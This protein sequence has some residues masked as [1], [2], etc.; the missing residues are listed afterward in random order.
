MRLRDKVVVITGS[1]RGIG[2]AVAEACAR[3]GAK[4]VIC[5]RRKFEVD[6]TCETLRRQGSQVTGLQVDVSRE[7]DLKKLMQHA[8]ETWKRID[9]WIN[10]AGVSGGYRFLYDLS[11]DEI[12]DI[13]DINIKGTLLACKLIIP[14]FIKNKGGILINMSG[15]GGRCETA[16]FLT[17][18]AATKAAVTSFTKSL[19]SEN[20]NYPI[21]IHAVIPG[22]VATDFYKDLKTSPDLTQEIRNLPHILKA[23]GVPADAVGKAIAQIACQVPGKATGRQYSLLSGGRL[24]RAIGLVIWYRIT[25]RMK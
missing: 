8:I 11:S 23:F 20:K 17:T 18:Y 24:L 4:I 7:D 1:T 25:G 3:E 9:V 21:S 6:K 22:M 14:Y 15:K 12:A 13:I 5:S 10:N 16:P 19:A 2:R